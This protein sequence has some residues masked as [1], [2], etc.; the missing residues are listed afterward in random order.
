MFT[1]NAVWIWLGPRDAY[2]PVTV[3]FR[4][5][6]QLPSQPR[7]ASLRI[8]ADSR[9]E[10]FV[11]GHWFGGGPARGWREP[12]SVDAF[13]LSGVLVPGTNTLAVRVHH[14]GTSTFQ[15]LHAPPGL[16]AE[17]EVDDTSLAT[18]ASWSASVETGFAGNVPR[19]DCQQGWEE[20]F[21]VRLALVDQD[22]RDW[23]E[24]EFDDRNWTSAEVVT[25]S[26]ETFEP[27]N[28]P[29]LTHC[30]LRPTISGSLQAVRT[31]D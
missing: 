22:G 28:V 5:S 3:A 27:R 8:T 16:I 14:F 6:F 4:R 31:A 26:H 30:P 29:M 13:D 23:R 24:N 17:L 2:T 11:N 12:W 21:D 9:Y 7:V 20:Q 15:Y 18:D 10:L 19:I 25:P 1:S